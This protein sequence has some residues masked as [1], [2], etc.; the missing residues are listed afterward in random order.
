MLLNQRIDHNFWVETTKDTC[1]DSSPRNLL[2][3]LEAFIAEAPRSN[4]VMLRRIREGTYRI[5]LATLDSSE[6]KKVKYLCIFKNTISR[7]NQLFYE[8]GIQPGAYLNKVGNF[9]FLF[10]S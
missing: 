3:L 10:G 6:C 9:L 7:H 2:A 5:D 8:S 4:G 1:L